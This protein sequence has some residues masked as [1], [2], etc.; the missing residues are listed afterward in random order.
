MLGSSQGSAFFNSR[1][2]FLI[3]FVIHVWC[4]EGRAIFMVDRVDKQTL[5]VA[6]KIFK[7][8]DSEFVKEGCSVSRIIRVEDDPNICSIKYIDP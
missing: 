6:N 5:S 2:S 7:R 1:F 3:P 4:S 8:H